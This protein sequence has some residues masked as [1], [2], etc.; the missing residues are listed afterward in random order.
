[1]KTFSYGSLNYMMRV[2]MNLIATYILEEV[3]C[4]R[5][6]RFEDRIEVLDALNATVNQF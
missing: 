1:M 6:D 2:S 5:I 4:M 3:I